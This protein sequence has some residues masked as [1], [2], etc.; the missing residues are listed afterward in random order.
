[1]TPGPLNHDLKFIKKTFQ[2]L[3]QLPLWEIRRTNSHEDQGTQGINPECQAKIAEMFTPGGV[4]QG[5]RQRGGEHQNHKP[6]GIQPNKS[7][8][9]HPVCWKQ[10]KV[11]SWI[12]ICNWVASFLATF[13]SYQTGLHTTFCPPWNHRTLYTM[14]TWRYLPIKTKQIEYILTVNIW[15]KFL[16]VSR[17]PCLCIF[18]LMLLS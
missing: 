1:M 10:N 5:Q 16:M 9:H 6:G 18:S 14:K 12:C 11:R 8:K 17:K 13:G 3:F 4:R 7:G 2:L 15:T